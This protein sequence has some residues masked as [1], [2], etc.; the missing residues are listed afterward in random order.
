MNFR[1]MQSLIGN[2]SEYVLWISPLVPETVLIASSFSASSPIA[3][4]AR[5]GDVFLER[6]DHHFTAMNPLGSCSFCDGSSFRYYISCTT[7]FTVF[8]WS[9]YWALG[10]LGCSTFLQLH[11]YWNSTKT[12][13]HSYSNIIKTSHKLVYSIKKS[14]YRFF[15]H[16][17]FD[18]TFV[19]CWREG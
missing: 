18:G 16:I 13:K 14:F 17:P 1:R 19:G 8:Q 4:E 7:E 10:L 5:P 2:S 12:Y 9:N 6:L 11:N 3:S 15:A